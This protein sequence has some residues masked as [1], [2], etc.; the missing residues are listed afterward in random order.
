ML[1]LRHILFVTVLCC[2]SARTAQG[3]ELELLAVSSGPDM[4]QG[5]LKR[6][7][8]I[9]E[10]GSKPTPR[11]IA[12]GLRTRVFK[13]QTR[14]G[15]GYLRRPIALDLSVSAKPDLAG[16]RLKVE[17]R[18]DFSASKPLLQSVPLS[19]EARLKQTE[20][21]EGIILLLFKFEM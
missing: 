1:S 20:T 9:S 7:I 3:L 2:V 12:K 11:S 16:H 14:I 4:A 15:R 6:A 18:V 21:S 10:S 13:A 5:F 19:L 8:S 17:R